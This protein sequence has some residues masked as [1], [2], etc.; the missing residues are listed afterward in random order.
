[1]PYLNYVYNSH[2]RETCGLWLS[3]SG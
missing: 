3:E 1:L 2:M